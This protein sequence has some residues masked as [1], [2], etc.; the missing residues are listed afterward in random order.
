MTKTRLYVF[1]VVENWKLPE[2]IEVRAKNEDEAWEK[3]KETLELLHLREWRMLPR[4]RLELL[5]IECQQNFLFCPLCG[6]QMEERKR[7]PYGDIEYYC[8]NCETSFDFTPVAG[9]QK[10]LTWE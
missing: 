10:I 9:D 4:Y 2:R 5:Q 1:K 3:A 8:P 6:N 7:G